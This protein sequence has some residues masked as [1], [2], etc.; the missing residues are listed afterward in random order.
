MQQKK[1]QTHVEIILSFTIFLSAVLILFLF[2]NP[3][4]KTK[5]INTDIDKIK[6]NIIKQTQET[7]NSSSVIT[8]EPDSCYNPP[9]EYPTNFIETKQ[10]PRKYTLYF[11]ENLP[12]NKPNYNPDCDEETYSLG[13]YTQEEIITYQKLQTLI[14]E[15]DTNYN[16]LKKTLQT[17]NDFK[18]TFK[19]LET[20]STPISELETTN[21]KKI[22]QEI[23]IQAKEFPIRIMKDSGEIQE[24]LL[25]IQ[26]W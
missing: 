9:P 5:P 20:P 24:I 22:P 17:K 10:N 26:A 7:I 19:T 23:N 6:Q 1:S 11:S 18:L 8:T 2:L 15:Y 12:T 21:P 16:Q 4:T 25:N 3:L 13:L 14:T